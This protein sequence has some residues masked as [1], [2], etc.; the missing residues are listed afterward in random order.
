MKPRVLRAAAFI[1]AALFS[2]AASA[3]DFWLEPSNYRPAVGEL[4]TLRLRVGEHFHGDVVPRNP[5]LIERFIARQG[6]T[7][8]AIETDAI[9]IGEPG[10]IVIGYRSKPRRIELP[11]AKFEAYLAEEGLEHVI[12]TRKNRGESDRPGRELFSRSSKSLLFAGGSYEDVTKPLGFRFELV[13]EAIPESTLTARLLFE[14]RPVANVLV[15]AMHSDG[16]QPV[17]ARS[18]RDGRVVLPLARKG[19]WL[20]KAVHMIEAKSAGADWESL[21]ASL[22]FTTSE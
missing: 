20:A 6:S 19:V 21:W 4:V 9:G 8:T 15:I 11:A 13:P 5:K 12:A 2:S 7:E 17:S 3:H 16:G 18:D 14:G 22:T 1:A 10:T